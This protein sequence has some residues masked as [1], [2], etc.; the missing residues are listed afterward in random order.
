MQNNNA[1]QGNANQGN[2]S[3]QGSTG[4]EKFVD[5]VEKAIMQYVIVTKASKG[6]VT[7]ENLQSVFQGNLKMGN[8]LQTS[9]QTLV[10]DGHIKETNGKYVATDDGREDVQKLQTIL[11]ELPQ[12]VQQNQAGQ[13]QK[14]TSP[15]GTNR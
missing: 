7:R 11:L 1:N 10:K 15:G 3:N 9:L 6:E 14:P 12:L 4:G 5:R 2:A 13:G 8:H